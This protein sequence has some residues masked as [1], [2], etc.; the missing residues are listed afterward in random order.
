MFEEAEI[1]HRLNMQTKREVVEASTIKMAAEGACVS[2][3]SIALSQKEIELI[4]E[5]RGRR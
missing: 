3:P 1:V 5:Y 4:D 2:V